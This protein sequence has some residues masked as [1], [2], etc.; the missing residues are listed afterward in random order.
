MCGVSNQQ[1]IFFRV[2]DLIFR[3]VVGIPMASDP[4]PFF[5]NL[6]L[7]YYECLY[8][9]KMRKDKD[10]KGKK[11]CHVF[12]CIDDIIAINDGG[13][14]E[15]LHKEIY[16][17][18]LD[19]KKE[20]TNFD[21]ATYLDLDIKIVYGMFEYNFLIRGRHCVLIRRNYTLYVSLSLVAICIIRWYTRL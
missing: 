7:F 21:A 9:D 3:Q 15:R 14:F 11:F 13:E 1:F 12:R 19:L 4:V 6:Y 18:E 20:N 17:V 8:M 16:P 2:G 10:W 5:A